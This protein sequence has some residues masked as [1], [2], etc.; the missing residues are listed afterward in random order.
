MSDFDWRT[1][2]DY[3]WEDETAIRVDRDPGRGPRMPWQKWLV[4]LGIVLLFLFVGWFI[5]R[6]FINQVDQA[7]GTRESEVI[8]SYANLY[9]TA[10]TG[11]IEL[12]STLLS[13]RDQ[14]WTVAYQKLMI[15]QG[16]AD[17]TP[18]SLTHSGRPSTVETPVQF[19]DDLRTAVITSTAT[20]AVNIGNGL[21][22]T[23]QLQQS[24]VFRQ[25]ETRWLFAPPDPEFWGE[26]VTI[27][28]LHLTFFVPERDVALVKKLHRDLSEQYLAL[29]YTEKYDVC[30]KQFTVNFLSDPATLNQWH[31]AAYNIAATQAE[32]DVPI[33]LPTPS[34]VGLPTDRIGYIAL[35]GGYARQILHPVMA[36][37][38]AYNP[39]DSLLWFQ[40]VADYQLAKL[41]LIAWPLTRDQY[42][43]LFLQGQFSSLATI[44]NA[45]GWNVG[46]TD[47]P[48]D[49]LVVYAIVE[50]LMGE[51][52]PYDRAA[53][54]HRDLASREET[55]ENW[56]VRS[57]LRGSDFS[58]E[59]ILQNWRQTFP[60]ALRT[61]LEE[62]S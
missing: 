61:Y 32:G 6:Q 60:A 14:A 25:G 35:L 46:A 22:D 62:K 1:D 27:S 53:D 2:A 3:D 33:T 23:V 9:E 5:Y 51:Y 47:N 16:L 34:L 36:A 18:L 38:T 26:T 48:N 13:G 58:Q 12:F 21:T 7:T 50:Y 39:N 41:G 40:A 42:G 37:G 30:D 15:E 44:R 31:D 10:A 24:A 17:R 28:G 56:L 8:D 11:D 29:C 49:R 4:P 54:L 57:A 19:A 43:Q 20:Y 45:P 52:A 59:A 55:P